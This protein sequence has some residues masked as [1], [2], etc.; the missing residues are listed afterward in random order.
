MKCPVCNLNNNQHF[1]E[2]K[3]RSYNK[4]SVCDLVFVPAKFYLNEIDEKNIYDKHENNSND[5]NYRKFLSKLHN[6]LSKYL[7]KHQL[8]LDFGCGSGPTLSKMLEE[9]G[10]KIVLYDKYYY[11]NEEYL[12]QQFD[13][14]VSTEVFEHL[15]SPIVELSRLV[16]IL[17]IKGY[18]GIMT[19]MRD[20]QLEFKKWYY[21]NDPTHINFYSNETFKWIEN[22][23]PLEIVSLNNDMV[24]YL[25][26][27]AK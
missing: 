24:I 13:F 8:G 27:R 16:D 11:K 22:K 17:V 7:K 15:Q 25:K 3:F 2:D 18:L 10:H 26:T 6:P 4:C 19:K 23:Y 9:D 5:L 14:I 1:F 12:N 20:D 21:K